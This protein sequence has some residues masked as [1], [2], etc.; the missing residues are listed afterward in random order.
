[1]G[2]THRGGKRL[3]EFTRNARKSARENQ[4]EITVGF[5]KGGQS[6]IVAMLAVASEFGLD[7]LP[8]RPVFR[9]TLRSIEAEARARLRAYSSGPNRR[10][11][12]GITDEQAVEFGQWLQGEL[13]RGYRELDVE[14]LGE[15]ALARREPGEGVQPLIRQDERLLTHI[16]V[17]VD[18]VK[19]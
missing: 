19:V 2:V 4:P 3:A 9:V 10:G 8:E 6:T 18:G 5:H 11:R 7:G 15:R 13:R 1:M 12:L 17:Q 16:T 14:P